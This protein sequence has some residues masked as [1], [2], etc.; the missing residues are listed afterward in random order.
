MPDGPLI[1]LDWDMAVHRE[2]LIAFRDFALQ[3]PDR[4]SVAPYK[5]YADSRKAGHSHDRGR[6]EWALRR[7]EGNGS[8][9][10]TEADDSCHLFGFGMLYLPAGVIA[11]AAEAF[12]DRVLDDITFAQ[13]LHFH[14]QP[15]VPICWQVRPVHLHY[16]I[17]TVF[18]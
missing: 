17:E 10:C 3:D 13:W 12:P 16:R 1:H 4:V 9:I 5:V 11:E 15:E 8:R 18:G 7:L 6:T 14:R 2:D